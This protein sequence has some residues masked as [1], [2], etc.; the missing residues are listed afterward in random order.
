MINSAQGSLTMVGLN[1]TT[2]QVFWNGVVVPHIVGIRVDW[3]N[4]EQRIKLKVSASDTIHAELT[5]AGILI[6]N[7]S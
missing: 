5:A 1:T 3:E 6:K 2:P 4:D 7:W